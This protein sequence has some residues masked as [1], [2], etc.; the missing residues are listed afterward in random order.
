MTTATTAPD[1]FEQV[2]FDRWQR[3]ASDIAEAEQ[4]ELMEAARA[5][6]DR[7]GVGGGWLL[8]FF[9]QAYVYHE[10]L[11]REGLASVNPLNQ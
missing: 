9:L 5:A 4:R 8:D 10:V 3:A 1:D 6:A 11:M 7:A 2:S